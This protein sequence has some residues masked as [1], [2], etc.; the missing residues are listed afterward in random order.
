MSAPPP[1]ARRGGFLTRYEGLPESGWG[2]VTVGLAVLAAFFVI[3]TGSI[4]VAAFDPTVETTAAKVASQAVVAFG[5]IGTALAFALA[6]AA[7]R[8][9]TAFDR[10]GLRRFNRS[11][12]ALAL[13]AFGAYFIV[14]AGLG[15]LV[16]PDQDN[17][18]DELGLG[19]TSAGTIV[20][21]YVLV[22][23]GAALGEELFFRGIVFAGLRGS[24]SL[25]PAALI[26]SVLWGLLHL[27]GGNL[28]V[29]VILVVFGLFLAWLYERTGTIWAG[30]VAHGLNNAI[31]VTFLFLS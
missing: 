6:D 13:A 30:I 18:R 25:W 9:R 24:M 15:A 1:S 11:V 12:V 5:L 7:G 17:V 20:I 2:P 29:V 19:G 27:S 10:F 23:L 21:T 26:S 28:G 8:F 3:L 31:A 14:Q 22:V 4:V 16:S